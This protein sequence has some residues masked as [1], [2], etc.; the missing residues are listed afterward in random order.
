MATFTYYRQ[1]PTVL[2][3]GGADLNVDALLP[4]YEIEA[5]ST[6]LY[7]DATLPAMLADTEHNRFLMT[8]ARLD[9]NLP[10][11]KIEA[12]AGERVTGEARLPGIKLT[13]A[14][15]G[16]RLNE[17]M[18]DLECDATMLVGYLARLN[19]KLPP[20]AGEGY[21]GARADGKLPDYEIDLSIIGDRL[22]GLNKIL[23]GYEIDA[24][25]STPCLMVLDQKL[26]VL[27]PTI[28]ISFNTLVTL[29]EMLPAYKIATSVLVG[30]TLSVDRR[31]SAFEI[32]ASGYAPGL[33]L[34]AHLPTLV[35]MPLGTGDKAVPIS[36]LVDI[37][38][39]TDYVMR[40][41][42]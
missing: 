10:F 14:R 17:K 3:W 30:Q 22:L 1:G 40:H 36:V 12:Q 24:T 11:Y 9:K 28:T 8:T 33:T 18:G 13:E 19:R 29:D 25:G 6:H 34:D 16:S 35:M 2:Y 38:R 37:A 23:P 21:F 5:G 32:D 41:S 42:R 4:Y 26:P 15:F 27:R 20:L 7:L 31:L 39:Y